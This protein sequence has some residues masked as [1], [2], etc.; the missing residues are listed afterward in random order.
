VFREGVVD[1]NIFFSILIIGYVTVSAL[2]YYIDP[3]KLWFQSRIH[4]MLTL[5]TICLIIGG[6]IYNGI[7]KNLD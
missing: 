5:V 6:D 1:M 3:D 2:L 4:C 7:K